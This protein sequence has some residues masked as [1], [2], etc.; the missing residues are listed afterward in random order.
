MKSLFLK[1]RSRLTLTIWF[2]SV[3]IFALFLTFVLPQ[4]SNKSYEVTQT[5]QS[6]DGSFF[7]TPE[8]LY[9]VAEAY[10]EA[11]R[12]Y[13]IK[14]RFTFDLIWPIVYWFFLIATLTIL[15]RSVTNGKWLFISLLPSLGV[16]FDY[17]ENIATSLIMYF[18]PQT[19]SFIGW[20]APFFTS[21][22]WSLIYVSFFVI[23][24]GCFLQVVQFGKKVYYDFT[25]KA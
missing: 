19:L 21:I 4:V 24:I 25:H 1:L 23:V 14:E 11:G 13:Y 9:E 12:S 3:V 6:P 22:K 18:Y 16:I 17:L 20:C 8:K 10:G 7:Y 2:I 5:T 15:Y